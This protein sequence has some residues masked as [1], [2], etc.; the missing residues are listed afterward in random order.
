MEMP[1]AED[2]VVHKKVNYGPDSED[3]ISAPEYK[4]ITL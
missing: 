1:L 4:L 3:L 2:L